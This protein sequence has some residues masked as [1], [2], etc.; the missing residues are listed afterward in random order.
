VEICRPQQEADRS[1]P[2]TVRAW[3]VDAPEVDQRRWV[4]KRLFQVTKSQG[5]QLEGR[6]F[7][8][9][10]RLVKLAAA[11]DLV[12]GWREEMRDLFDRPGQKVTSS[13][14]G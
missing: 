10:E 13:G 2:L 8:L 12:A 5:L 4:I 7:A 11:D 14:T 6:Q 3:L 9:A 1:P